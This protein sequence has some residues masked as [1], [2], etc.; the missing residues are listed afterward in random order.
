M[1]GQVQDPRGV[2]AEQGGFRGSLVHEQGGIVPA[3]QILNGLSLLLGVGQAFETQPA[4]L[5]RAF[6]R[7]G[8]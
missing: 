3:Q 5:D 8:S 6:S 7:I 2:M 4:H 1:S